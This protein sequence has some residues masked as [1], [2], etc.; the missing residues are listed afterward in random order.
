MSEFHP[1]ADPA[2]YLLHQQCAADLDR[3]LLTR[4]AAVIDSFLNTWG[5]QLRVL[6]NNYE[7]E[8]DLARSKYR[9]LECA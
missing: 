8:V 2:N 1:L 3:V 7:H 6:L 4:D 9:D 5:E